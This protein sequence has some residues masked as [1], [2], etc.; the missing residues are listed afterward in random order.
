MAARSP[1]VSPT[2][3]AVHLSPEERRERLRGHLAL[4]LV[5]L[6]FG[7]FP[8]F[9]KWAFADFTPRSVAAWRIAAGA[10][11]LGA[12]AFARY[13]ARAL[14]RRGDWLRFQVCAILGIV[15]NMLLYLEGLERSTAVNAGLIMPVIPVFT[16][17]IACL[18][19]QERF[20]LLRGAGVLLAFCGTLVLVLHK[21]P[22][23]SLRT[24]RGNVLM[25]VNAFSYSWFLVLARPLLARHP[26]LVVIAWIFLLSA[27]TLP[28]FAFGT[29]LAPAGAPAASW[30]S[31]AFILVFPTVLAYLL[32]TY[33]LSKVSASTTAAY[34]FFQ[35]LI[36]VSVGVAVLDE[37]LAPGALLAA[38]LTLG[39][40]WLVAGRP[41]ARP[42]AP[43]A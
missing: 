34:I 5:Q 18:L 38:A 31:L 40:V 19:R 28:F 15:L 32:N 1:P 25:L 37:A 27:W 7:L 35:P 13:G 10:L 41:A 9:G 2:P 42:L 17:A 26:P 21:G 14:P 16:F 43:R 24:A 39:G 4:G 36:T 30:A 23:L 33:A 22:E 8:I 20:D 12:V 29:P 11:A 6:F 3:E